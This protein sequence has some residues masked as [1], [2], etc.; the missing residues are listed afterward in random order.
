LR[1]L[2]RPHGFEP[3]QPACGTVP[4]DLVG[5][6]Y[7][8][9][10]GRFEDEKGPFAHWFDGEGAILA[11]R[12]DNGEVSLACRL[13]EP[14]GHDR[15]D[16]A[17]RPRFSRAA[18][19]LWRRL[20]AFIDP[21]LFVNSAN[22]SLM[23]W[24]GRLFALFEAGL[25]TEIDPLTLATIGETDLGVIRRNF[26]AHPHI[27]PPSGALINQAFRFPIPSC[28]DYY[29]LADDGAHR[30][31]SVPYDGNILVHDFA[32][33][34][35]YIISICSP[36]FVDL[37]ALLAGRPVADAISWRPE[38]GTDIHVTPVD[39]KGPTQ[40]LKAPACVLAHTANAYEDDD[41]II[42]EAT[43]SMDRGAFDWVSAVADGT[44]RLP[45]IDPTRLSRMIINPAKDEVSIEPIFD[46]AVEL[47]AIDP[48]A[49]GR[50]TG[51]VYS[52]GYAPH[53][54]AYGDLMNAIVRFDIET[55]SVRIRD[56]GDGHFVSEPTFV[57]R[58]D[59]AGEGDGWVLSVNYDWHRDESYLA[60]L[61]AGVE[62]EPIAEV[63]LL[64]ALPLTFHGVWTAQPD[65][66]AI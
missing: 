21:G 26:T 44:G 65:A 53:S 49:R 46:A 27:H 15:P 39:G 9:G 29:R 28:I 2:S 54:P 5:C 32:V 35:R 41:R 64:Q 23:H 11:L 1:T 48:V 33:T 45:S 56:F 60:I 50:R 61:D 36:F 14:A 6:L 10:P 34:D 22:T 4:A 38:K 66:P 31:T 30:L 24:Q 16:Y 57:A 3:R 62:L 12:F 52:A 8:I 63:P 58:P 47:P 17:M 13:V 42:V 51:I 20:Q 40:R 18:D 37:P 7:R 55:G 59:A 43:I 19:G 25:P